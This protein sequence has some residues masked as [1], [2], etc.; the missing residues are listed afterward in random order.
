MTAIE[1][2]VVRTFMQQHARPS[3]L[4]ELIDAIDD[5]NDTNESIVKMLADVLV[6]IVGHDHA[7]DLLRDAGLIGSDEIM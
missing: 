6:E 1:I 3:V 7:A 4:V 2:E 5:E